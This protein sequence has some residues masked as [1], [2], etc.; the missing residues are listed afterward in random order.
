MVSYY[1]DSMDKYKIVND[2]TEMEL[3]DIRQRIDI[4]YKIAEKR[5]SHN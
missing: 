4:A 3:H 1:K 2:T 5:E